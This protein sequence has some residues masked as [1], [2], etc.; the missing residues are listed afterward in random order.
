MFAKPWLHVRMFL[1]CK[2]VLFPFDRGGYVLN[3]IVF[4]GLS[5]ALLVAVT[6]LVHQMRLRRA[7][8][9]LLR[10]LLDTG[11]PR[12]MRRTSCCGWVV[13]ILAALVPLGCSD[14]ARLVRVAEETAESI[15]SNTLGRPGSHNHI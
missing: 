13:V 10:R 12:T 8:Q 2:P 1:S 11:G 5:L 3:A 14:D 9:A 7:L 4:V 15:D 6:A